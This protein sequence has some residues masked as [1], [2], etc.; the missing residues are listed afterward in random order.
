MIHLPYPLLGIPM[1]I[2]RIWPRCYINICNKTKSIRGLKYLIR[3]RKT[4]FNTEC[5]T[6]TAAAIKDTFCTNNIFRPVKLNRPTNKKRKREMIIQR[7]P[8]LYVY[9]GTLPIQLPY[10]PKTRN[11]SATT[12]IYI[13]RPFTKS[14]KKSH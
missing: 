14:N 8:F 12:F 11:K 7:P 13:P 3:M 9:F 6:A 1:N 4:I 5:P 10:L 2:S